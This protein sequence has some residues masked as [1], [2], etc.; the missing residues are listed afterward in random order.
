MASK[1]LRTII[2]GSDE[3][4]RANARRAI[5]HHLA[6]VGGGVFGPIPDNVRREFFCLDKHTW[7][8]HE[9]WDDA[10][11]KHRAVTTRYDVRPSGIVKSQGTN[12]YQRLTPEEERNFR[13]A[14]A[15]YYQR[16]KYELQL[17]AQS[18]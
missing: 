18:L 1:L 17:I 12:Q 14:S 4:R 6:K 11:G 13:N 8:W 10:N 16:A 7:V 9:E 5:L 3:Q 2:R 15:V